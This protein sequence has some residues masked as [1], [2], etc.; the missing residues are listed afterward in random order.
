ML[1]PHPPLGPLQH[2]L[3]NLYALDVPHPVD[4]FVHP[5]DPSDPELHRGEVLLVGTDEDELQLAL[6]LAPEV[7]EAL[8]R[9]P[10]NDA[11]EGSMPRFRAWCLALE[12]VSHFVFL[13]WAADQRRK[14]RELELEL[15]A[16]VDKYLVAV[17]QRCPGRSPSEALRLSAG[18][19]RAL[20][21][22]VAFTDHP[23]TEKGQRYRLAHRV[24]S[25]YARALE[26]RFVRVGR[27]EPLLREVR[28]F[29]R[30]DL[31]NKIDRVV[32]L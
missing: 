23:G 27:F 16:D 21:E 32:G 28:A 9:P 12:G 1:K 5:M 25:R 19:R 31:P 14:V 29:Y 3:S 18:V 17:M 22:R 7:F 20:F 2:T 10:E 4:A 15:Q 26:R 30:A 11:P 6:L 13:A 24:A 8:S